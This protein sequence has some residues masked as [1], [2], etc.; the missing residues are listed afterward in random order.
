MFL[1]VRTFQLGYLCNGVLNTAKSVKPKRNYKTVKKN[2]LKERIF[3]EAPDKQ[4]IVNE[5][6]L[7]T[8]PGYSAWPAR[9]IEINGQTIQVEFFGT[10]ER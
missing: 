1:Y 5:I 10:G 4:F 2:A 6:V 8:V 7:A 3:D 9:I